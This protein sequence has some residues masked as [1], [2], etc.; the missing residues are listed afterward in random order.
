MECRDCKRD[1]I[2][3]VN[4]HHNWGLCPECRPANIIR[5]NRKYKQTAKG[6]LTEKRWRANPKKK[7]I[8]KK[9]MQ[10]ERAK[11]LAVLRVQKFLHEHPEY[12]EK[13]KIYQ[14][15]WI[16]RIVYE[17]YK[18][19]SNQWV[20]KYSKTEK[21]KWTS[22][23]YKYLLRNNEAGKI[24]KEI[25]ERKLEALERKCQLCGT[26]QNITIDHIIPLSKGG[27]NHDDNL[28]PL[29]KSCNCR[30]SNML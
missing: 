22:R 13:K 16:E 10:K 19:I 1:F 4:W 11:H 2:P 3:N 6:K 21:G 14:Q 7:E 24:D 28:Q 20:S 29:C 9:G 12:K 15:H 25:W 27:T 26:Q 17:T 30:K 5:L 8:D 23:Q 18:Q